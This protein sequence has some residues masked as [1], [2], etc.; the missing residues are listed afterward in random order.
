MKEIEINKV[1]LIKDKLS[2]KEVYILNDTLYVPVKAD[3]NRHTE[4]IRKWIAEGGKVDE[5]M[6]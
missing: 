4:A 5:D 3:G 1:K 2:G 6:E